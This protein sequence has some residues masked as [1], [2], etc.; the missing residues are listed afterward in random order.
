M[1]G[2]KWKVSHFCLL[3]FVSV[4]S[5]DFVFYCFD[6]STVQGYPAE[7]IAVVK[8]QKVDDGPVVPI[9]TPAVDVNWLSD[10]TPKATSKL[11][12]DYE[13]NRDM[14]DDDESQ[15]ANVSANVVSALDVTST[16]ETLW[17]R[18]GG[19]SLTADDRLIKTTVLAR[20]IKTVPTSG[21]KFSS[22]INGLAN[23]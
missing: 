5:N 9:M 20:L 14:R 8:R 1:I 23:A 15:L 13:Q 18:N 2:T 10:L 22:P 21:S 6:M 16:H 11:E 12:R 7:R 4:G 3:L 19:P 17:K